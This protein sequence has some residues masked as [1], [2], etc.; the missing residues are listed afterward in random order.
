MFLINTRDTLM[1]SIY[2]NESIIRI[3]FVILNK[4]WNTC[5]RIKR[6]KRNDNNVRKHHE[7]KEYFNFRVDR[8]RWRKSEPPNINFIIE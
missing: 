8:E 6:Q 1:V 5:Q 7:Y 4:K 2:N 3:R